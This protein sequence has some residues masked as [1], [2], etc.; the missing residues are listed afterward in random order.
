M[1]FNGLPLHPLVVHATVV[2]LPVAAL[3]ALGYCVP[4]WRDRLR[5]PLLVLGIVSAGL[6]WLTSAS[7]HDLNDTRFATATGLLAQRI[8]HHADLAGKLQVATY[9][10]AGLTVLA[11]WL[12]HRPGVVRYALAVLLALAAIG[13]VVLCGMTG[14]AGARAA[15]GQ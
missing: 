1:T 7:G 9:V 4:R 8:Q 5:W 13:V 12:H 2:C 11:A 3:V 6:V 10:F 15:W 14:D